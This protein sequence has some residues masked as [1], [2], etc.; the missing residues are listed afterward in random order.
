[1]AP[2]L[3]S[4]PKV[5]ID[6]PGVLSFIG[7]VILVS[8][9]PK[10]MVKFDSPS[11]EKQVPK[12]QK[13]V[14][15]ETRRNL[16][17][18]IK[19]LYF[20]TDS[21]LMQMGWQGGQ[22]EQFRTLQRQQLALIKYAQLREIL[23]E[24]MALFSLESMGWNAPVQKEKAWEKNRS[25]NSGYPQKK[26]SFPNHIRERYQRNSAEKNK[27]INIQTADSALFENQPCIGAK[28][29][30][31]ILKYR[32]LLGGFVEVDQLFEVKGI[33]TA[34]LSKWR[35]RWYCE[36]AVKKLGAAAILSP[37]FYHP[38]FDKKSIKPFQAF[39]KNHGMP[40][41]KEWESLPYI[42][43]WTRIKMQP[44]LLFN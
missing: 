3:T 32:H 13:T 9:V 43:K 35:E 37:Q 30:V 38:Y 23:G 7:V 1:M 39:V 34:C 29:A 44:Y 15:Q 17:Q 14:A 12:I 22:I 31:R 28:L 18:S 16:Y 26:G 2:G 4:K 40:T 19:Q 20:Q 21:G 6:R 41:L 24:E 42:D 27:K 25:D 36:G 11:K 10:L 8:L 33:D 5:K